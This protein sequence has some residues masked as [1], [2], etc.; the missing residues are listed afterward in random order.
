MPQKKTL[1]IAQ[2]ADLTPYLRDGELVALNVGPDFRLYAVIALNELDYRS[3]ASSGASFAKTT[4][5]RPQTYRVIAF[6]DGNVTLDI[7][8]ANEQFNIHDIQPLPNDEL[9]LVCCRSYYK[10][11]DDFDKNGRIYSSKGQLVREILLGDGIQR[12]QTTATGVIWTSFFDEGIFGNYGWNDPIGSSGLV[13]WDSRGNKLYEFEPRN[14]LDSICDCYALNIESD[15][16]AWLYYY[17]EFPL[18][19]LRDQH[20]EAHWAMPIE[21]SNAFAVSQ[22]FALF[23]GGYDK[24]DKYHLF[25][26]SEA[27]R[28]N[29]V[30]TFTLTDD[31]GKQLVADWVF[32]RSDAL[33]IVRNYQ[34]YRCEVQTAVAS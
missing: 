30:T 24:R 13:A 28:T 20:I 8:I 19:H 6:H 10:G 18:V 4:P 1:P 33:Y 25:E 14:G 31:K 29:E 17:T 11:P 23:S 5:S 3:E 9:L 16:S 2:L 26:L 12:V 7:H 15:S 22:G 32:A 21:G 27:G 34:V